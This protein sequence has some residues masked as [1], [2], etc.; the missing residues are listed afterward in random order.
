MVAIVE[1]KLEKMAVKVNFQVY[2]AL[3]LQNFVIHFLTAF[4]LATHVI[5]F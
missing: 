1:L 3:V 2:L 5:S 4:V